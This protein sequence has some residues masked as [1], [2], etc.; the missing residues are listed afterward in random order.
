LIAPYYGALKNAQRV[1]YKPE[2]VERVR[3]CE[4]PQFMW[5]V[6]PIPNGEESI[7]RLDHLQ[8]IG[9]HTNSYTLSDF[10]LTQAAMEIIDELL[11][12]LVWGGVEEAS[13][14]GLYREQIES[15]FGS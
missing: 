3:H 11:T 7:L 6:L 12:W 8:P 10:R 5:D 2:F 4:Y 15:T 1:G 9:A 14:I 13:W